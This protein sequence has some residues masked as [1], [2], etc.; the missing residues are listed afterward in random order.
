MS[1]KNKNRVS[2]SGNISGQRA[3]QMQNQSLVWFLTASFDFW[4]LTAEKERVFFLS[5][6]S[7]LEFDLDK[8]DRH[9]LSLFHKLN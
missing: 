1:V 6:A 3:I 7:G 2:I 5:R 9:I 8:G 4:F